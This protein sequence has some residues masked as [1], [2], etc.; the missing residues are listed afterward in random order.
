MQDLSRSRHIVQ[1]KNG[2]STYYL[3][4]VVLCDGLSTVAVQHNSMRIYIYFLFKKLKILQNKIIKIV[5]EAHYRDLIK[6]VYAILQ[7]L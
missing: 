1:I 6:P 7:I 5:S 3:A 2:L 4:T